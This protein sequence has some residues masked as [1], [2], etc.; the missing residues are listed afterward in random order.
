MCVYRNGD[1]LALGFVQTIGPIYPMS[2]DW[3][4]NLK[5]FKKS[6]TYNSTKIKAHTGFV[7]EYELLRKDIFDAIYREPPKTIQLV[8]FSQGSAVATLAMRD[9]MYNLPTIACHGTFYAS[10][11]VYDKRG[12]E[13][14]CDA[15]MSNKRSTAIRCSWAG[16]PVTGLPPWIFGFKHI[17]GEVVIGGDKHPLIRMDVHAHNQKKYLEELEK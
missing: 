17:S 15:V 11:R 3:I 8:G 14:F 5:F 10:P 2:K 13:E 4:E 16:D 9:I 1:E 7:E 6:L 12:A